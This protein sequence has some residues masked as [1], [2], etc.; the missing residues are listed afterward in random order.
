MKKILAIAVATA[1]SAPAMADLTIGGNAEYKLSGGDVDTSSSLETNLT[2]TGTTEAD[3]I[4]VTAF[5]EIEVVGAGDAGDAAAAAAASNVDIDDQYI[6]IGVA[7]ATVTLAPQGGF[8]TKDAFALGADTAA[9]ITPAYAANDAERAADVAVDFTAGTVAVQI[10]GNIADSDEMS[11]YAATEVAGI[12]LSGSYEDTGTETGYGLSASVSVAD[13]TLGASYAANDSDESTSVFSAA[14]G[15]FT[16]ASASSEGTD[17]VYGEYA[18]SVGGAALTLAAGSSDSTTKVVAK[19][20][21]S[22]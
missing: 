4:S 2:L 18:M 3:G 6:Q 15:D 13:V 10:A 21:Y 14:Y 17:D 1:I 19:L 7:G 5:T 22:F 11:V 9:Q 12:A 8:A 16:I 20:A